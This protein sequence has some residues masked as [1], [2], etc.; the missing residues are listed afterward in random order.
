MLRPDQIQVVSKDGKSKVTLHCNEDT[1][2]F[3][4]EYLTAIQGRIDHLNKTEVCIT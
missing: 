1:E 4:T 3:L 2:Q